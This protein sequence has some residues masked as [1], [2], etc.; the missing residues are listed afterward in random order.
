M[1]CVVFVAERPGGAELYLG[2]PRHPQRLPIATSAHPGP[3]QF[4]CLC[5]GDDGNSGIGTECEQI[6]IA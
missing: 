6:L 1:R 4:E 5:W 3:D 2:L